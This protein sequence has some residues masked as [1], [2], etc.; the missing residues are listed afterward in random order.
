MLQSERMNVR[1]D[2]LNQGGMVT[3]VRSDTTRIDG[4]VNSPDG[5]WTQHYKNNDYHQF[6][7][8]KGNANPNTTQAGLEVAKRQLQNNPL[9]HSLC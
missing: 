3:S 5:G 9:S 8:Y 2:P 7:A 6:N 1:A 4:R